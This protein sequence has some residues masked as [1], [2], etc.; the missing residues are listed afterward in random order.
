MKKTWV[1]KSM[2]RKGEKHVNI[3]NVSY[4]NYKPLTPEPTLFG[5]TPLPHDPAKTDVPCV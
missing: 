3:C 4:T 2:K 1:W 5:I